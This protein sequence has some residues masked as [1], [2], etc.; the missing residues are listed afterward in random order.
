MTTGPRWCGGLLVLGALLA[1]PGCNAPDY[2]PVRD[3]AATAS[4][5]VDDPGAA[6]HAV[7]PPPGVVA[8]APH[9]PDDGILAMQEALAT[10][11]QAVATLASDGVLP[12]RES[13]FV[14]L[15]ARAR[16]TSVPGSEA[17]AALGVLLR[18]AARSNA[19]APQLRDTIRSAD[20]QVQALVSA[21]R[22]AVAAQQPAEEAARQTAAGF[23]SE[24]D[25][26]SSDPAARQ[27]LREWARARDDEFAAQA[28]R[29][30][31]YEEILTR[32]AEGHALL[33]GRAGRITREDVVQEVRA[34]ED[35]LRRAALA[36]RDGGAG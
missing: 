23:Y 10:Y 30:A 31:R 21:L 33:K 25:G 18:Y 36:L 22:Q 6:R 24:I 8:A 2:S 34:A 3:W 27:A 16:E 13:P 29:R 32:V 4:L 26:R 11:L 20:P 5:A 35:G 14:H 12:Y 15:A 28:G 9:P 17:I 19:Q 1:L 7:A